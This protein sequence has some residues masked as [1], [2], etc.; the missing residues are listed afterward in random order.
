M[1]SCSSVSLQMSMRAGQPLFILVEPLGRTPSGPPCLQRKA[2]DGKGSERLER[3]RLRDD[4]LI[5]REAAGLG[6]RPGGVGLRLHG[7]AGEEVVSPDLFSV[8][9]TLGIRNLPFRW[10]SGCLHS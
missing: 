3:V 10:R 9:E 7:D 5:F 2:G 1:E 8:R 4:S 6:R